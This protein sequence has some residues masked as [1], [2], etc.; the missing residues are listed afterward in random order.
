MREEKV[1]LYFKIYA[2]KDNM[3]LNPYTIK[4]E[5]LQKELD[6]LID[7]HEPGHLFFIN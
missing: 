1:D 5:D 7:N 6:V 2:D 3:D 4:R